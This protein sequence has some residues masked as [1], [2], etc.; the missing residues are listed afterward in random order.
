MQLHWAAQ[1]DGL[2]KGWL[3][4]RL[5]QIYYYVNTYIA[6]SLFSVHDYTKVGPQI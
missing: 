6:M 1:C 4:F 5:F 3:Y 2:S